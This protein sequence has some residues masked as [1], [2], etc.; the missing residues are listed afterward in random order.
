MEYLD[1]EMLIMVDVHQEVE[2]HGS[3]IHSQ[4]I[5]DKYAF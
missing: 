5:Q 1:V 3:S 4:I 2:T